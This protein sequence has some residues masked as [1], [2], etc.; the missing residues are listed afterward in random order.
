MQV[1]IFLEYIYQIATVSSIWTDLQYHV[2]Q[3]AVLWNIACF[4]RGRFQAVLE[5]KN[6]TIS[7]SPG[8]LQRGRSH[9]NDGC[10]R[11]HGLEKDKSGRLIIPEHKSIPPNQHESY[12]TTWDNMSADLSDIVCF[13]L[14][15][16]EKEILWCILLEWIWILVLCSIL[17]GVA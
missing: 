2:I 14:P 11:Q 5:R 15:F 1:D 8:E 7:H 10:R 9:H 17:S 6:D 16:C 3:W 4:Y 12:I 13:S